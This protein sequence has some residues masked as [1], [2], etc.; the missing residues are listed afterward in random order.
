MSEHT[1]CIPTDQ[2]E[3]AAVE[4]KVIHEHAH[5]LLHILTTK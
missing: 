5:V 4:S 2:F 1:D 3:S